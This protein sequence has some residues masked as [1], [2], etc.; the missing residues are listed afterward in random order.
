M[1]PS[2][3]FNPLRQIDTARAQFNS[4]REE[5]RCCVKKSEDVVYSQTSTDVES[6]DIP[7]YC[8]SS[9][10]CRVKRPVASLGNSKV[11]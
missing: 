8:T 10:A 5:L 9:P 4:A 1:S 7:L 3:M 2:A 11:A 6:V